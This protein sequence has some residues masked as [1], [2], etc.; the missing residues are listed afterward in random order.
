MG[1]IVR[2]FAEQPSF[3]QS[4]TLGGAQFR[5]RLTWKDRLKGWYA[6]LW[7]LSGTAVLL[8][9]RVSSRWA[10]GLGL[11]AENRPEGVFLV[12]GPDEYER[13]SL[14]ASLKLVFYPEAELPEVASS[15]LGITVTVA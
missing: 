8:G 15:D 6:D 9:Q 11:N 4:L 5:L 10:L 7:T 12:R 3:I 14:G 2:T 1:Q 13:E